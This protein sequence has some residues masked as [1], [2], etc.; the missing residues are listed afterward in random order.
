[1]HGV[2]GYFRTKFL[3]KVPKKDFK[4]LIVHIEIFTP[5]MDR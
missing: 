1:M 5:L 4:A 2:S 3:V